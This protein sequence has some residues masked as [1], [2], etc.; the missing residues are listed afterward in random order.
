[1][2]GFG[3]SL[4]DTSGGIGEAKRRQGEKV[5]IGSEESS[6]VGGER[7]KQH[8]E[9]VNKSIVGERESDRHRSTED[10]TREKMQVIEMDW[11]GD[12]LKEEEKAKRRKEMELKKRKSKEDHDEKLSS[13]IV[14]YKSS[15]EYCYSRDGG[16]KEAKRIKLYY[17]Q[18]QK[19]S[20]K[21]VNQ[22]IASKKS[23]LFQFFL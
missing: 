18:G 7:D 1:M 20:K 23:I 4:W 6:I 15:A 13:Q 19:L 9:I 10:T 2:S 12:K 22:L 14:S 8:G 5:K 11:V 21:M 16:E 17:F 3:Y